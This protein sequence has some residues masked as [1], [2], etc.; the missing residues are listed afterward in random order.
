MIKASEAIVGRIFKRKHGKGH[1]YLKLTEEIICKIFSNDKE[2][3]LDDFEPI[4]ITKDILLALNFSDVMDGSFVKDVCDKKFELRIYL[5]D[6]SEDR[7][8]YELWGSFDGVS[9]IDRIRKL[10]KRFYFHELQEI[11]H[12][13]TGK[14]LKNE[15]A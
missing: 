11:Y 6:P 5:P 15:I 4:L 8:K 1:T 14:D 12:S 2:Y 10:G 3:A 13:F 7:D 9:S